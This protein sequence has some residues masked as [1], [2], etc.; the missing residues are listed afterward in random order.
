MDLNRLSRGERIVGISGVILAILSFIGPWAKYEFAGESQTYSLWGSETGLGSVYGFLPKLGVILALVAVV[1]VLL[2]AAGVA[3]NLPIGWGL[4][5]VGLGALATLLLLIGLLT[6]PEEGGIAG[7]L[8]QDA[9]LEISRG[10]FLFIGIVLA[11]VMTYGGYLH[12]QAEGTATG[13]TTG[14]TPPPPAP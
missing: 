11:A 1:L 4:A 9:G 10:L 2:R 6:G 14:P 12:M 13:P 7:Q 5:Y 8:A 3:L